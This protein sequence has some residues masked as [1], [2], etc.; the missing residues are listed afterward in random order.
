MTDEQVVQDE[1]EFVGPGKLLQQARSR[2]GLTVEQIAA[3]LNLKPQSIIDIEQENFDSS[4]SVTFTRGYLKAYAKQVAVDETQ[5]LSA[6]EQLNAS[7]KEP[8]K[9]QSFSR[10]VANQASDDRLMLVSY[11]IL[12]LILGLFVVWWWQQDSDTA[13]V[14]APVLPAIEQIVEQT[15][16]SEQITTAVTSPEPSEPVQNT[17]IAQQQ[18]LVG[19]PD[20]V[21]DTPVLSESELAQLNAEAQHYAT[22]TDSVELVEE[23]AAAAEPEVVVETM[24]QAAI[25]IT[26]PVVVPQAED[27]D[28]QASFAESTETQTEL[29]LADP[30]ELVFEFSADCWMQLTDAT[31]EAIAYGV[32]AEGRIM[33]ISGVP[34]F[35]VILGA[36]G[37]VSISYAG[38]NIDMSQ[39]PKGRTARFNLPLAVSEGE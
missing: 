22:E 24:A 11:V 30:V 37:A 39:F 17:D 29:V 5:V 35:E 27:Q 2:A 18:E 19:E 16:T 12:I 8:A 32:K 7:D 14:Q 38:Q 26:E 10:R 1:V 21:K 3:K 13:G 23:T 20:S 33:P 4:I 28:A 9:L 6:F 25:Q 15:Q 36:P 31:G 34:P